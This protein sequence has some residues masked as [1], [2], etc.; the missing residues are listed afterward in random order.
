MAGDKTRFQQ[1]ETIRVIAAFYSDHPDLYKLNTWVWPRPSV[2]SFGA[3]HAAPVDSSLP[4]NAVVDPLGDW[5]Q[6]QGFSYEGPPPPT[7]VA[8]TDKPTEIPVDLNEWLRFDRPGTYRVYATMNRVINNKAI[9]NSKSQ[10]RDDLFAFGPPVASNIIQLEIVPADPGWS[11]AQVQAQLARWADKT[12]HYTAQPRLEGSLM[13]LGTQEAAQVII[14]HLG[15][16]KT[17]RSSGDDS[18]AW[19]PALVGFRDRTWLIAEMQRALAQP[20]YPV[21]Q[22]FLHTLTLLEA[23]QHKP[24]TSKEVQSVSTAKKD[25]DRSR[26]ARA[27]LGEEGARLATAEGQFLIQEWLRT[28]K[29]VAQKKGQSKAMTLHTLSELAWLNPD[30]GQVPQI[31][32]QLPQLTSELIVAFN[33]LPSLPQEY[34]LRDEWPHIRSK[35]M[36]PALRR[37]QAEVPPR[38]DWWYGDTL[39][40]IAQRLQQLETTETTTTGEG[41]NKGN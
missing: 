4:G 8:L 34:L 38:K 41:N 5:L 26:V 24:V 13:F 31:A 9:Q 39:A 10:L 25:N 11:H 19:Q 14:Q 27:L 1:G 12:P 15:K 35:A 40:L 33:A 36:L 23:L 18:I 6:P 2:M 20:D 3:F 7:P 28:A 29:A 32:R 22:G 30:V 17:P 16:N 21:T 37:L